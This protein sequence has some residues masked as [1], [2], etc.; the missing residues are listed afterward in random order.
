MAGR[1]L[2]R[3]NGVLCKG[4]LA[5]GQPC[6]TKAFQGG[7]Y[8]VHCSVKEARRLAAGYTSLDEPELIK[9]TLVLPAIGDLTYA[10][11]EE[12]LGLVLYLRETNPRVTMPR[13]QS[14]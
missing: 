7:A 5:N 10:S 2:G 14:G 8:C 4:K 11:S 6:V 1:Q 13:A 3:G 12:L 9:V